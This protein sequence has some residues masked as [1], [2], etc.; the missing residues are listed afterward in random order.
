MTNISDLFPSVPVETRSF[1]AMM[2]FDGTAGYYSNTG[3]TTSG[4]KTSVVF[5]F[6]ISNFTGTATQKTLCQVKAPSSRLRV[7]VAVRSS[8]WAT[9]DEQGKVLFFVN[10]SAGVTRCLLWSNASVLDGNVHTVLFSFDGDAGTATLIIDGVAN[11][12]TGVASRVAPTAGTLGTG[13]T[14]VTLGVDVSLTAGRYF[15]GDIGYFGYAD[16]YLTNWSD[17]MTNVGSPKELDTAGWTEWGGQPLFWNE[18]G[19]M[20][21]NLGSAGDMTK[22]GT[23]E[24]ASPAEEAV[25]LLE[26]GYGTLESLMRSATGGKLLLWHKFDGPA[27]VAVGPITPMLCYDKY[28]IIAANTMELDGNGYLVENATDGRS[29]TIDPAGRWPVKGTQ[30]RHYLLEGRW[31]TSPTSGD[32]S[33]TLRINYVDPNNFWSCRAI[34]QNSNLRK[35]EIYEWNASAVGTNNSSLTDTFT[36]ASRFT[37]HIQDR[38]DQ[39][40]LSMLIWEESETG[41][42]DEGQLATISVYEASRPFKT[43]D[44]MFFSNEGT[45]ET[46]QLRSIAIW[47]E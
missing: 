43:E 10:D 14:D 26:S 23:I 20:T 44:T 21:N 42:I 38:G 22:N 15:P 13:L 8:D 45:R 37:M 28:T 11:D 18:H 25:S 39:I 5:R 27:T 4:N 2:E 33:P 1:P 32:Y 19:D 29:F 35:T 36:G 16:T 24:I 40:L 30:T 31:T 46:C 12:D 3:I 41:Q 7:S 9:A 17:F 34:G 6:S 47:D